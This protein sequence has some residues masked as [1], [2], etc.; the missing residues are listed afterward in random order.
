MPK[1]AA[2]TSPTRADGTTSTSK[3][4]KT[5]TA[6]NEK[7]PHERYFDTLFAFRKEHKF[8]G[9]MLIK[10]IDSEDEEIESEEEDA[11]FHASLTTEQ[12][13]G[14]RFVLITQNRSDQLDAMR[15][16]ILG[17]QANYGVL[18]FNTSFSYTIHD[19]FYTFKSNIYNR[20]R[21][22]SEKFDVLFA[23]TYNLK[24][25]DV[26][27]QDNEGDMSDMVKNLALMWK[28]LLVK[29]DATLGIDSE[30]T[31]PGV[32]AMLEQFRGDLEGCMEEYGYSFE[33][34]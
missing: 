21:S 2:T 6:D 31:R 10:G 25:Y 26:W 30:Y 29:D 33:Y 15:K 24:R 18:M 5:A 8:L 1:N 7:T 20:K 14:M 12:M 4:A 28:K 11:A 9:T 27:M 34:N 16:Y 23:Y 17:K 3:K 13:A 19:G 32:E 22:W